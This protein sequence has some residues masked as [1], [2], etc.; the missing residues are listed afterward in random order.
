MKKNLFFNALK[1]FKLITTHKFYVFKN[2]CRAGLYWQGIVHDLSKYSFV[3]FWESIHYYT[4]VDSPINACKKANGMSKAWLHHK[5]RNPHHYEYW[6][7][8]FDKGGTPLQMPFKYALELVCDYLAA[9]Q[10][11]G[12]KNF[13]MESEYKWWLNKCEQPIAMHPQTKIFVNDMLYI[14]FTNNNYSVLN[15]KEAYKVYCNA[16]EKWKKNIE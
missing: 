2:C 9:G 6:Q 4:G 16:T 8:N 3:E 15:K 1:H 11:Y 12:K 14:M 10:A 7:D 13:T 5:G